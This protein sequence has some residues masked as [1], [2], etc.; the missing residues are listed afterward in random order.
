[1][2]DYVEDANPNEPIDSQMSLA[3]LQSIFPWIRDLTRDDSVT[4][5]MIVCTQ[6]AVASK[7]GPVLVFFERGGDLFRV[8][9]LGATRR[10]VERL[11][12]ALSR[13]L[14]AD[15]VQTPLCDTRLVDGSRV[16]LCVAPA[17]ETPSITI[18]RFS[19]VALTPAQLVA[20]GSLPQFVL[21]TMAQS[22]A[23]D[24]NI[25]V[26]G[27]TGSG[28]TTL[29]NALIQMFPADHRILVIED[30]IELRVDQLNTVR[31]EA[32]QLHQYKLTIRDMVRHALRQRP[33]HIVVGEIRGP[34]AQDVLQALNTGHGGSLT[35]LH[36]NNGLGALDRMA[37]FVRQAE[38][39]LPWDVICRQVA[40]ALDLV[41]HQ[42]RW[43]DGSRGVRELL[44]VKGYDPRT[45]EWKCEEV[46]KSDKVAGR[47]TRSAV[48]P[49]VAVQRRGDQLVAA[50]P[51]AAGPEVRTVDAADPA[52]LL[53]PP[54]RGMPSA[55]IMA[56]WPRRHVVSLPD[57][58]PDPAVVL[59][60][61]HGAASGGRSDAALVPVAAAADGGSV[62]PGPDAPVVYRDPADE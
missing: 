32:R 13:P 6:H 44:R 30:T 8:S 55:S 39:K 10:D 23:S 43:P 60:Y 27:G 16:A 42:T 24:G 49:P 46:W 54:R 58:P 50:V 5:I 25:L 61:P 7:V 36:S 41:V 52:T 34:E 29:L 20:S 33:D 62:P 17:T 2:D 19:K 37:S 11:T 28:K 26:A 14:G 48:L 9:A 18:R 53:P 22:L 38:D 59:S 15:P 57:A 40:S 45:G 35:T 56:M 51:G 1:M 12:I 21:D 31:L 3:S 47:P 4:E